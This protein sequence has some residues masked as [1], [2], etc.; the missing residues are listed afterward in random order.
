MVI[1]SYSPDNYSVEAAASQD[2]EGFYWHEILYRK[3]LRYP[4]VYRMLALLITSREE[5]AAEAMAE[6]VRRKAEETD[7][8]GVLELLGPA[9][10]SVAKINDVY[11]Y[12]FYAK[13]EEEEPLLELK[14]RLEVLDWGKQV[15]Y[16]FDME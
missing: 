7:A 16:Q 15:Q 10:A 14:R 1:Q 8:E 6:T 12:L 4:P 13:C 3:L 9:K 11:R 2:Y 5:A